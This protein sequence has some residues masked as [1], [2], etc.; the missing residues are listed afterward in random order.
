MLLIYLNFPVAVIMLLYSHSLLLEQL[1]M[2]IT[3]RCFDGAMFPFCI[4]G[5]ISHLYHIGFALF[6]LVEYVFFPLLLLCL[7]ILMLRALLVCRSGT[8]NPTI[9]TF[10]PTIANIILQLYW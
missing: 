6:M 10:N 2:F 3:P 8:F 9:S 7:M 5:F 1:R 4:T